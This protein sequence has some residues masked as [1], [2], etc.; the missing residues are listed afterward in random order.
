MYF[1]LFKASFQ[2]SETVA[3]SECEAVVS[4]S[5]MGAMVFLGERMGVLQI[6]SR[7]GH[8]Q[9]WARKRANA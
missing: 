4:A 3:G 2:Q 9:K 5:L 8:L 7:L 1:S 6:P